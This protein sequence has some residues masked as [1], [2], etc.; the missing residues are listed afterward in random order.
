MGLNDIGVSESIHT[1]YEELVNAIHGKMPLAKV[2]V[3]SIFKRKDNMYD[4]A[5]DELNAQLSDDSKWLTFVEHSNINRSMMYDAKHLNKTGFHVLLTNL[6]YIMFKILPNF[7]KKYQYL[8]EGEIPSKT[9][10]SYIG[11]L[12]QYHTTSLRKFCLSLPHFIV[13]Y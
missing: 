8:Y 12:F 10:C 13:P 3:S 7:R 5:I 1:T 4:N 9:L 2:Y 6:K 11:K